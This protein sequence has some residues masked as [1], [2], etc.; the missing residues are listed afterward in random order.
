MGGER[1]CLVVFCVVIWFGGSG[2]RMGGGTRAVSY[3][4]AAQFGLRDY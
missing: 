1:G 4:G 2:K 3:Y